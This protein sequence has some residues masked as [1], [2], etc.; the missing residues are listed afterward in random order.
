M[1]SSECGAW[2]LA[3]LSSLHLLTFVQHADKAKV[4]IACLCVRMFLNVIK[5]DAFLL[6][7]TD[8]ARYGPCQ[9]IQIIAAFQ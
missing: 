6:H 3:I 4:E 8:V 2:V 9:G 1:P 5:A 7:G